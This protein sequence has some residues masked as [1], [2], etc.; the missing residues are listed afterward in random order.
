MEVVAISPL[1]LALMVA[2]KSINMVVVAPSLLV[3]DL[4]TVAQPRVVSN[5]K[6]KLCE[7]V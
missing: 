6:V 7:L 4:A 3:V 2:L 5:N 1:S